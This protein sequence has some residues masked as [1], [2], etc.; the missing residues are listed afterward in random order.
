[1]KFRAGQVWKN[2]LGEE[3]TISSVV[4]DIDNPFPVYALNSQQATRTFTEDG[5]VF[6]NEGADYLDL[7]ELVKEPEPEGPIPGKFY[8]RAGNGEKVKFLMKAQYWLYETENGGIFRYEQAPTL[9]PWEDS[10]PAVEI[11][12][13]AVI[14]AKDTKE[15]KRGESLSIHTNVNRAHTFLNKL[16]EDIFDYEIVELTG[17]LPERKQ[18]TN[19]D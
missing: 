11:K 9:A 5:H 7:V 1:M 18:T 3:W 17:T 15:G 2:V 16:G 14:F 8:K 4:N 10:L 6:F 12:R 19:K 13:W